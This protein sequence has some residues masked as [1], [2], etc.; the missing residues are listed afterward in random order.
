MVNNAFAAAFHAPWKNK[1]ERLKKGDHVFL[2]RSRIG[3]VAHGQASGDLQR[4]DYHGEP[5]EAYSMS[6]TNFRKVDPPLLASEIKEIGN[7]NYVF[8][9][10]MFAV[11]EDAG[12]ELISA[13][14]NREASTGS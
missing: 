6:L 8:M 13:L 3:I 12:K 11:G 4:S 2:Y 7:T 14:A 1:I 10:T 9:Q 5:E